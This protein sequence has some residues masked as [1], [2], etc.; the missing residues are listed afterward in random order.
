M[1]I[2]VPTYKKGSRA[3]CGNYRGI[4]TYIECGGEGLCEGGLWK[5][6]VANRCSIDGRARWF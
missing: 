3:E 2:I 6:E 5:A 1:A 4:S